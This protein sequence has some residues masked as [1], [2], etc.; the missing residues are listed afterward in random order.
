MTKKGKK[1]IAA[2]AMV[3]FGKK[4]ELTEAV[5]L[6]KKASFSK[7]VGS[8]EIH[9]K[10]TADPKYNDQLIRGTVVLPHGTG[11]KVKVAA[12]VSDDKVEAAKKAGA[13]IAGN[14]ELIEKID[15]GEINFDV[16]VT[17]NDMMR[18]LAKVAKILGPK[19]LMPSPKAGT[20][21]ANL[22]V[23]IEEIKKGRVEFKLDKTGN[24]HV[25]IGKLSFTDQ[26]LQENIEALLRA[27]IEHKPSGIKGNLIQKIVLAP[28]MGPGVPLQR[29]E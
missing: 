19:G 15:K 1:F 29:Q 9:V 7:F 5:E 26:Q 28:T 8:L 16:L 14:S 3:E 6:V 21:A 2:K 24:V 18:D 17:T 25:A 20:V 10:T 11:K 4:Y 23:A 12:F 22:E 27:M 13:D